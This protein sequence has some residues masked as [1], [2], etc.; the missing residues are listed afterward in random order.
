MKA[1]NYFTTL[2]LVSSIGLNPLVKADDILIPVVSKPAV[3]QEGTQRELTAAQISELLPWAKDSKLFLIDL[4]ES[5]S[6]LSTEDKIDRLVSGIQTVVSESSPKNSELLM[7]YTLNRG[8]V[9]NETLTNEMNKDNVG[10]QDTK[11]RVLTLSIHMAINYYDTDVASLSKKTFAPIAKFGL[12]YFNFLNEINKSIF[13]ASAQYQIQRIAL[14]WFQWDLYRDLNN[15]GYAPQIVKINNTLKIYPSKKINDKEA[16][17]TIRQ[18][19]KI[20]STLNMDDIQKN[21]K[22]T[23]VAKNSDSNLLKCMELKDVSLDSQPELEECGRFIKID[24][25]DFANANYMKCYNYSSSYLSKQ[26]AVINCVSKSKHYDFSNKNFAK[27]I[28]FKLPAPHVSD[29]IVEDII[30]NC[31]N[32]AKNYSKVD[33]TSKNFL[34][35][36]EMTSDDY[37]NAGVAVNYCTHDIQ[38]FDMNYLDREFLSC[39]NAHLESSSIH[40][41]AIYDCQVKL[42]IKTMTGK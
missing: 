14:E 31:G 38:F 3:L 34:K 8:L 30:E 35:C 25:A 16:L 1:I 23:I 37:Y 29:G 5:I 12:E 13:D 22:I 2:L 15:T 11:L 6:G 27:C 33:F 18:M 40:F 42:G 36:H 24:K 20:I 10:T 26:A 9:L 17:N 21:I 39:Y 19:K 7:R 32:Y 28:E 4:V 41:N